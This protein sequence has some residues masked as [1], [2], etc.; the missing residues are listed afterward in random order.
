MSDLDPR[1]TDIDGR[2]LFDAGPDAAY[3]VDPDGW[4][5]DA[6]QVAVDRYGYSLEE[7]RQLSIADLAAAE[8]RCVVPERIAMLSK[9]GAI[10][11]WRHRSKDGRELLVE[12]HTHPIMY[13]GSEALLAS[14]RDI[15]GQKNLMRELRDRNHLLDRILNT[16]PG[17]VYVFDLLESQNVFVNRHWSLA[18]GYTVE[19]IQQPGGDLRQLLHPEDLPKVAA[20]HES[21]RSG[22]EGEVRSIDYRVR[23]KQGVWHWLS[24]HET[25]FLRDDDGGVRQILGIANEVTARKRAEILLAGQ[26]HVLE[27]IALGLPLQAT[28]TSLV[29]LIEEQSPGMLGSILLLDRDGVHVRH[30]AAP[31]LPAEFMAAVDGQP[32]GPA[33]GSCGTAAFR[34]EAVIVEDIAINPLWELYRTVA[35]AHGLRACWS[36]PIFDDQRRVLGTFAMYYRH[37]GR[38][39]PQHWQ[40]IALATHVAAIAIGRHQAERERSESEARLRKAQRV[41]HMGFL[42]WNLQTQEIVCSDE[43]YAMY[44]VDPVDVPTTPEFVARLVHPDDLDLVHRSLDLAIKRIKPYDIDHRIQRADGTVIWVHAQ[45]ELV[46]NAE[47]GAEI[48]LGTVVD[49]TARKQAEAAMQRMSQLY[50]ALSQCNQAIVHSANEAELLPKICHAAVH[51]GGMKMA[52]IGMLDPST[53]TII[54]VASYGS[55]VEYL[56]GI[57]IS[58]D[59][60][61]PAGR[62]PTGTAVRENRPY[63]CQDFLGDPSSIPWR[64][65]ASK[66][67]WMSS[68][69]IPLRRE[70]AP[71]GALTLYSETVQAFDE[72]TQSLLVEMAMDISY[73]LDHFMF[74]AGRGRAE[75]ALR[76]SEQHLRTIVETEP[77]CVKVLAANGKLLEINAA[78]LTMLE[79]DSPEQVL[80]RNLLEFIMPEYREAFLDLHQRVLGGAS[81]RLQF[82]IV[83]MKGA[84]R[85]LETHA[86]PMR[87]EQGYVATVLG[88]TRDITEQR[89][90]EER[91]RYLANFDGLTGLPNRAQLEDHIEYAINMA[92]RNHEQLALMFFDIDRFKDV[93]DTLGHS[94]G[95]AVLIEV[96]RRL[97]NISRAEDAVSR[98]GGDEFVLMLPGSDARGAAQFAQRLL[99]VVAEPFPYKQHDLTVTASIGVA[100]FPEDGEDLETL[101]RKADT[102]MYRAK[103]E[104]RNAYRFFTGEMQ[105]RAARNMLLLNALRQALDR[106]QLQVHFQPQ[107]SISGGARLVGAEALLRWFHPQ[108]GIVSP[109]EFIPVAEDSGLILP[110]G[111]WT[112]RTAVRQ[113]R[114]WMDA[115]HQQM[116]IAVNVSA[117]QFRHPNLPDLVV[118]ILDEE[119]VSPDHL[120]LELTEGVATHDPMRAIEVM[121]ELHGRGIR[122]SIDDFGT[123]YSSLNYLKKFKAY[124]LKIDQSFVRDI[125]TDQ[126]DR[127]IVAAIISMSRNLGLQTIAEGVETA[128]QL[129]FLREQGCDEA[130]GYFYGRPVPAKQFEVF[131]AP[132]HSWSGADKSSA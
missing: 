33:A 39:E 76:A 65:R 86:A 124:K 70:G 126:E 2:A 54:P 49:I 93:N 13:R 32:I 69:V 26:N 57:E 79:A 29:G 95:D 17:T 25:P 123:G 20:H 90:N 105:A 115:G 129:A 44:G 18:F 72:Q 6:N 114:R 48:L 101:A 68:A 19:E 132:S 99:Q 1:G 15:S 81:D 47:R 22:R 120:E 35:L 40:L 24:S 63:W 21:W 4:I 89:L 128:E 3:V 118:R 131:L 46:S 37:P 82:E 116:V 8:L 58:T 28:L 109:T 121:N 80:E 56:E 110:I 31:S 62:G 67:G 75:A 112:L 42:H 53:S 94:F 9:A 34:R 14:A 64:G 85:W 59:G 55:G 96:A 11:E 98:L 84:R 91:I 117:V 45:A 66:F 71:V 97:K 83:G 23:D 41:A 100:M 113:L 16:E 78:G 92:K 51:F 103:H 111:E 108:L 60:S 61:L 74:E 127:A 27:M 5:L 130:Q 38:P 36:T 30:G 77:E 50:A 12:I 102:A 87:N 104:G 107:L 7:F 43:V 106:D 88:V 122:M 119:Q 125:G 73:A 52:W 10:F